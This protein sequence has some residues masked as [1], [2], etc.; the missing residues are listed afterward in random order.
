MKA[1]VMAGGRGTRFTP[2]K[3][4]AEVCGFPLFYFS[5]R[6]ARDFAEEVY[7]AVTPWSPLL[8]SGLPKVITPGKGYESDVLEAV[9]AVGYP[10]LVLPADSLVKRASVEALVR[11][12]E[13]AICSLT[14]RGEF[15]G[16]SLWRG[17]DLSDYS[18]VESPEPV[19]NVN[20]FADYAL[21]KNKCMEFVRDLWGES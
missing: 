4:L 6:L 10:S 12:C 21:A 13:S 9:R 1:V 15:V 18:S 3:P 19:L 20:T 5:Y 7:L 8:M 16:V 14:Y 17:E 2:L 11:Q